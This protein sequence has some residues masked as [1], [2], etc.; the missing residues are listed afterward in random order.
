VLGALEARTPK[1][2][3]RYRGYQGVKPVD[4]L[5]FL[6]ANS[7]DLAPVEQVIVGEQTADE[8]YDATLQSD[9]PETEGEDDPAE[10]AE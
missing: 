7:Y 5:N 3:W 9:E 4:Y 6:V 8:V 2:S 1:D 10:D